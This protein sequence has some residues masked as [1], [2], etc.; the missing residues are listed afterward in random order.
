MQNIANMNKLYTI[1]ELKNLKVGDVVI[2][3]YKD[4]GNYFKEEAEVILIDQSGVYFNDGYDFPFD[5]TI[6]VVYSTF[7]LAIQDTGDYTFKVYKK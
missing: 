4:D 3:E 5:D 7:G 6:S 1:Q 2:T